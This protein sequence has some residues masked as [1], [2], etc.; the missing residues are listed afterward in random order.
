MNKNII[1]ISRYETEM[2]PPVHYN[3]KHQKACYVQASICYQLYNEIMQI[4]AAKDH[5]ETTGDQCFFLDGPTLFLVLIKE[6]RQSPPHRQVHSIIL[7]CVEFCNHIYT[8][9][10]KEEI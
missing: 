3:V 4:S 5:A 7:I 9:S 6:Y 2:K 10:N 8:H 1:C